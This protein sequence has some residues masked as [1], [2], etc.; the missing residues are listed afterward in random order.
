MVINQ[1]TK[2][3]MEMDLSLSL[4]LSNMKNINILR[5]KKSKKKYITAF[6][7]LALKYDTKIEGL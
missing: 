3:I 5:K 4:S 6:S 1:N 7:M 2:R